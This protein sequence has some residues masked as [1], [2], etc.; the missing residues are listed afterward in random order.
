[1]TALRERKAPT[2]AGFHCTGMQ[3]H[4]DGFRVRTFQLYRGGMNQLIQRGLGGTIT[5]PAAK[6]VVSDAANA[7]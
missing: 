7:R 3:R 5:V 1:M 2:Q 6:S 4:A